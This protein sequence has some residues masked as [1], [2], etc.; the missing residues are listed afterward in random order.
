MSKVV[1]PACQRQRQFSP[2]IR[3]MNNSQKFLRSYHA[4]TYLK[5][6]RSAKILPLEKA[7]TNLFLFDELLITVI[8]YLDLNGKMV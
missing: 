4:F 8:T 1:K 3:E 5:L 6:Q 2:F 7:V